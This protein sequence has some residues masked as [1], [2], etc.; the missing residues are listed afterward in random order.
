MT[1]MDIGPICKVTMI[2]AAIV[3]YLLLT[4]QL[5]LTFDMPSGRGEGGGG[6]EMRMDERKR[7]RGRERRGGGDRGG[8]C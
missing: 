4:K 8:T 6:E 1:S 5:L 2:S 7:G 3:I